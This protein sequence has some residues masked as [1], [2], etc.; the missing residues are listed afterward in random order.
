MPAEGGEVPAL[1]GGERPAR[2]ESEARAPGKLR[3]IIVDDEPPLLRTLARILQVRGIDVSTCEDGIEALALLAAE[4][5]DVLLLDLMLPRMD[6]MEVLR[7]AKVLRP[8]MEVVMMTAF[9]DVDTAVQAVKSGAYDFLTKPFASPDAVALVIEKAA[10]RRRLIDRTRQLEAALESQERYGDL[11]GST[12]KMQAVFR[13]IETVAQS[14]AT[15]LVRGESG[16]GKELVARALHQRGPRAHKPF[17]AVNCSA[18]PSTLVDS[19]LFGHV[20]GAFTGASTNREGLF[21]SA[22]SGTIFLDEIGD[23]PLPSQVRLLR[24]LQEG[25]VKPVGSNE[26]RSVDVRVIVAT[27]VDLA[28]AVSI[29]AFREDLYYRLA[30]IEIGIPPLRDRPEDIPMLAVHFLRKFARKTGRGVPSIDPVAMHSL[31]SAPWPGNVRE[32]ENAIER[33]MVLSRGDTLV[34]EDFPRLTESAQEQ[35]RL[36]LQLG[37]DL[38]DLPY[39]DAKRVALRTFERH[40]IASVLKKTTGNVSQAARHAGLDRSNFRRILRKCGR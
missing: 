16:T 9:G 3:V 22:D 24:V 17:V 25:E 39:R 5:A 10:E 11:V 29:G 23:L 13:L 34:L 14:T 31:A 15:V 7:R 18:I 27:N 32:L 33:A 20:R 6:G 19:E 38:A 28:H 21:A 1:A 12:R 8:D 4:P 2:G 26:V 40:Y 36:E 37:S 30:V 35:A